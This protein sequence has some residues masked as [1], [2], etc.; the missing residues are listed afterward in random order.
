MLVLTTLLHA[1][2]P[3][4]A[5]PR[6]LLLPHG[7]RVSLT[8]LMVEKKK[9]DD[10]LS[11]LDAEIADFSEIRAQDL[12]TT[13]ERNAARDAASKT[14][15]V[16]KFGARL[17]EDVAGE[18]VATA[19]RTEKHEQLFDLG[20]KLMRRGEYKEAV[21][22]Y[23][24]ATA[25]APGGMG[26]RKGGQY[27][28]YLAQ[29]LQ[30]AGRKKEAVGLLQRCEAHPDPDV[31]KI[32]NNVLYIMQAPELKL[33]ADNFMT[34]TPIGEAD[35]WGSRRKSTEQK[36]PPPEKYSLEWYAL[37]GEKNRKAREYSE[38][39]AKEGQASALLTSAAILLG[40]VALLAL[41]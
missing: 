40:T 14:G 4:A 31:R 23:T 38:A 6:A 34:I 32:S 24:Q 2:A 16:N 11:R 5:Q 1:F 15:R 25:A 33:E 36:D 21:T 13:Q 19:E 8:P 35:N 9:L 26:N 18:T 20:L 28:I 41:R 37:E 7:T 29:A 27:A 30:A 39:K 3:P 10:V 22:A 17:D 12:K